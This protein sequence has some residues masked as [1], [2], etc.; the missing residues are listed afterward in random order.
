MMTRLLANQATQKSLPAV[1]KE[2]EDQ[3]QA[4]TLL[5]DSQLSSLTGNSGD[6]DMSE[7]STAVKRPFH[8][9]EPQTEQSTKKGG[10]PGTKGSVFQVKG[11][12]GNY[13][14]IQYNPR[15]TIAE[16]KEELEMLLNIPVEEQSLRVGGMV[17]SNDNK[18][19][20]A[21]NITEKTTV[22]CLQ[23]QRGGCESEEMD[24]KHS[25]GGLKYRAY[26]AIQN[27][28]TFENTVLLTG[29]DSSCTPISIMLRGLSAKGP[30]EDALVEKIVQQVQY[31]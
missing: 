21:C 29:D 20:V 24:E 14:K 23:K 16:V 7:P 8:S 3:S 10:K 1:N 4:T 26:V 22:E 2:A 11:P 25:I 30:P 19:L 13:Y 27:R 17:L 18:S 28:T 9:V 15:K 6:T 5:L 31:V 12:D